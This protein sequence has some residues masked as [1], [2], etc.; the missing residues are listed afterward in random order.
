MSNGKDP[1]GRGS[2]DN[3][4]DVTEPPFFVGGCHSWRTDGPVVAE[5]FPQ[6]R[7]AGTGEGISPQLAS[8]VS[9]RLNSRSRFR[10]ASS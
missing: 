6:I 10:A 3:Q 4:R 2:I 5:F 1:E 8:P 7:D 9:L